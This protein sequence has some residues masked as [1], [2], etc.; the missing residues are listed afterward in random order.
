[1]MTVTRDTLMLMKLDMLACRMSNS[2]V[3]VGSTVF[4]AKMV[5]SVVVLLV[6]SYCYH[7]TATNTMSMA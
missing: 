1:M 2:I 6:I 3:L 5:F 7:I 4:V